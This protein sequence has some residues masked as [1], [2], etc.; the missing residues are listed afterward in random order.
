MYTISSHVYRKH[1][2]QGAG[3]RFNSKAILEN[4]IEDTIE[5]PDSREELGD[6]LLLRKR[7]HDVIGR[8]RGQNVSSVVV[9]I[10]PDY[11]FVITAYPSKN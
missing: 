4:C 7:F 9:I 2:Q 11:Q 1:L 5:Y 8:S 10:K 6:R 3:S